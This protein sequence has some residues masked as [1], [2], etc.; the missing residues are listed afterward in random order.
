MPDMP[1]F[2]KNGPR[3]R[4]HDRPPQLADDKPVDVFG[5]IGNGTRQK[6]FRIGLDQA[7]DPLRIGKSRIPD[8]EFWFSFHAQQNTA[9]RFPAP[10]KRYDTRLDVSADS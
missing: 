5:N 4:A 8:N 7:V 1:Y 10:R 9:P 6:L 2:G 3:H